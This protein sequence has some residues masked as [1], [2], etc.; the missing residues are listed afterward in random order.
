M[1]VQHDKGKSSPRDILLKLE[2]LVGGDDHINVACLRG[3]EQLAV[4]EPL[5]LKVVYV[6]SVVLRQEKLEI[7]VDVFVEQELHGPG[8]G[9]TCRRA[10][11]ACHLT[12]AKACSRP[13]VG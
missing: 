3:I 8:A 4:R 13:T 9:T 1:N 11:S 6:P 10:W 5:P 12:T 7:V 2:V